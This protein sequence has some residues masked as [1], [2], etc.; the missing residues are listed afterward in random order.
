MGF[1]E[2]YAL[3]FGVIWLCMTLLW[4]LSL[5]IKDA[6]IVDIFWGTGFVI[7][8]WFFFWQAQGDPTRKL[9]VTLLVTLW[10][11]RL[12][13]H[14]G[15]RNIGRA[16]DFRY[17]QWR[18]ENGRAWWWRSYLKVFLLQG[19]IMGLVCAPVLGAQT[20]VNP[21]ALTWLDGLGVL[22]WGVGFV[23]EAVGDWQL[24]RFKADPA[25]KGR[26][27][28]RG[29]WRYTRHPNYFGDAVQW[30]GIYLLALAGGAWFTVYSPLLMT[31]L[32]VR[33]SGVAMLERSL[34]RDKPDYQAYVEA[35]SNF[36]PL[37]PKKRS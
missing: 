32:L 3:G 18:E 1:W 10:G 16:E 19:F 4:L 36:I 30:W 21:P 20:S 2:L 22:V 9:L 24:A 23:F 5:R 13:L 7:V 34:K 14:L 11:L 31:Y 8:A 26:V 37:P 29:L 33:V 27:M 25:N 12:T 15:A 35:T 6:S 28:N 17:A